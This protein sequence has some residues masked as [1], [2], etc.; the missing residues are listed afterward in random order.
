MSENEGKWASKLV[1]EMLLSNNTQVWWIH[2]L[3]HNMEN[4]FMEQT[5]KTVLFIA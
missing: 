5:V 3:A 4:Q 1:A 2:N